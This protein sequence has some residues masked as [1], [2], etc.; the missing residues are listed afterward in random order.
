M[1]PPTWQANKVSNK[2]CVTPDVMH[3]NRRSWPPHKGARVQKK[4]KATFNYNW[5]TNVILPVSRN[6]FW[7]LLWLVDG[8]R[9]MVSMSRTCQVVAEGRTLEWRG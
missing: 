1:C 2:Q 7:Y 6:D 4:L 3:T 8:M 5:R 9:Q